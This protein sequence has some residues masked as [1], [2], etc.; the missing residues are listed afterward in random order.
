MTVLATDLDVNI[1]DLEIAH[2]AEGDRGVV[3]LIVDKDSAA[4]L[5]TGLGNIGY[6]PSVS[7]L[8]QV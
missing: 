5:V 7:T 8:A 2:S 4:R 6:H 3:L 1:Y